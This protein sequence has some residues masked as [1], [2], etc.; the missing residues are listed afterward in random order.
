MAEQSGVADD[1]RPDDAATRPEGLPIGPALVPHARFQLL[2]ELGTGSS[3]TVYKARLLAPL[4]DLEPGSLVAIKF[5]RQDLLTDADAQARLR[6]EGQLGLTLDDP[7]VVKIHAVESSRILGLDCTYIVM[8]F[9]AGRSLRTF[10]DE[11]DGVDAGGLGS[12][13]RRIGEHTARGLAALHRN[14]IVHRDLKPENLLLTE[15]GVVKVMD[16]GLAREQRSAPAAAPPN[17]ISRRG[18]S[19]FFGSL[20]YAAPERLAIGGSHAAAP[21]E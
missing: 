18:S 11:R 7:H 16:L 10:L 12:F 21:G 8:E 15:D 6:A 1:S 14:G 4:G 9:I 5:L 19:G 13:A 17:D 3:G 20:A 2:D